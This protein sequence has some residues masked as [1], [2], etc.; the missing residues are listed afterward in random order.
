MFNGRKVKSEWM[1]EGEG[2]EEKE[3]AK[4]QKV[5][6]V[7][8]LSMTVQ[9]NIPIQ[10]RN[11]PT[12]LLPPNRIG[13]PIPRRTIIRG[14]RALGPAPSALTNREA[15]PRDTTIL[16]PIIRIHENMLL[17]DDHSRLPLVV[18]TQH[19]IPELEG[20]VGGCYGEGLEDFNSAG[21]VEAGGFGGVGVGDAGDAGA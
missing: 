15:L 1:D 11:L 9:H 4:G 12:R 21:A 20:A 8:E 10:L 2:R 13:S 17:L 14:L 3:R 16:N 19:F 7:K 18:Y 5:V 6:D